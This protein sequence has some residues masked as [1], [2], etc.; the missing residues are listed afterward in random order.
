V[1]DF[2]WEFSRLLEIYLGP[3]FQLISR[4]SFAV[5]CCEQT[6]DTRVTAAKRDGE[7]L[8][9]VGWL[10]RL[11]RETDATSSVRLGLGLGM[12]VCWCNTGNRIAF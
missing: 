10:P 4:G 12:K 11:L 9:K 2:D 3:T 6:L 1:G 7:A 8:D 5:T